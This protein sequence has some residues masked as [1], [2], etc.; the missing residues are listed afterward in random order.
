MEN[1]DCGAK[2]RQFWLWRDSGGQIHASGF[3]PGLGVVGTVWASTA[4]DALVPLL[5]NG[6][7]RHTVTD[8]ENPGRMWPGRC[9]AVVAAI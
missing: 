3:A 7:P 2:R 5:G 4:R 1:C 8:G 6:R 9:A